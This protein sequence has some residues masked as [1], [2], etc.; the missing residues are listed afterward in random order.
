MAMAEQ[1]DATKMVTTQIRC[2]H[3]R[4][5]LCDQ[6]YRVDAPAFRVEAVCPNRLCRRGFTVW[7]PVRR[8]N[9]G[10]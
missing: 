4:K 9:E 6:V 10:A 1:R 5:R 2:P 8:S 7:L 3:C